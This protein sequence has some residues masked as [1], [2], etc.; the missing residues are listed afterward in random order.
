[1]KQSTAGTARKWCAQH[2]A[3]PDV[4]VTMKSGLESDFQI[5]INPEYRLQYSDDGGVTWVTKEEKST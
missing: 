2:R 1:M 3:Q 5:E 4:I